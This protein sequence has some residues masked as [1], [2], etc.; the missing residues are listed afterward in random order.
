MKQEVR[1]L[2][3][4]DDV[5]DQEIFQMALQAVTPLAKFTCTSNGVDALNYIQ[6]NADYS[7]SMIFIDYNMP[8]MNGIECLKNL[9]MIERLKS[10]PIYIWTTTNDEG[11]KQRC[12]QNGGTDFIVKATRLQELELEIATLL[13]SIETTASDKAGS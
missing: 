3:I 2:L 11:I 12:K 4:E 10:V 8:L 13:S 6:E 5:D 1:C 7:P 9:R